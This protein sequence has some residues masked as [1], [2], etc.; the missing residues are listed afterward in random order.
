M[1]TVPTLIGEHGSIIV[2]AG[3]SVAIAIM[4]AALVW[5]D[6]KW[7]KKMRA[8]EKAA[9]APDGRGESDQGFREQHQGPPGDHRFARR[10]LFYRE[11]IQ[12]P[13]KPI[14]AAG[15]QDRQRHC[16]R[17]AEVQT[18]IKSVLAGK[19]PSSLTL[20]HL[21]VQSRVACRKQEVRRN[22]AEMVRR[23]TLLQAGDASWSIQPQ[24]DAVPPNE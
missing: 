11:T 20:I 22:V 17:K 6:A 10:H 18:A 16:D 21:R 3:F 24:S 14:T 1:D 15:R 8:A 9:A 12:T 19:C 5:S 2:I 7:A 23:G 4:F 13:A